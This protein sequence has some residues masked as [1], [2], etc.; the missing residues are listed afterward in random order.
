MSFR[1]FVVSDA[2]TEYTLTYDHISHLY[3][4]S[5]A[6]YTEQYVYCVKG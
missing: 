4:V 2:T 1:Y 6:Y 3:T 5:V